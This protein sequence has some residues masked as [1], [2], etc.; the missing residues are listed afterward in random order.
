MK[1]NDYFWVF[2]PA[3]SGSKS[4]KNKNIKKICNV[5]LLAYSIL[6]AKKLKFVN[7]IVVSSD[8]K[9]YLNIAKKYGC[10][11]LH[12][13]PKEF[14]KDKTS[15]LEV[16]KDYL[17]YLK[18]K[19]ITPPKLFVHLRP[20]APQRSTKVLVKAINYFKKKSKN[21]SSMRSVSLMLNPSQKT[22]HIINKKL[23]SV[24]NKDF[25]LDKYN[26][27]KELFKKTYLPNG[28][29]DIV[30]TKNILNNILHGKKVLPFITKL[31][32]DIDSI[33]DYRYAKYKMEKIEKSKK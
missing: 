8:S 22:M 32:L 31:N 2:I 3:R 33:E 6:A 20:T 11:L 30:K 25:N 16:F 1:K 24:I 17:N 9:K 5:P 15:D 29:I 10:N 19:N 7:N 4:I 27:P 13:R 23:C 18:K 28:Y 21:F 12:L 14:A 26:K